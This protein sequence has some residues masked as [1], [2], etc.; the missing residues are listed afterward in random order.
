[1]LSSSP[2]AAVVGMDAT[3]SRTPGSAYYGTG[4]LPNQPDQVDDVRRQLADAMSP[5]NAG[6]GSPVK[7]NTVSAVAASPHYSDI[8]RR[9]TY[10]KDYSY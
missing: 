5:V 1:M 6:G 7:I 4:A 9:E 10:Y 8:G 2:D 3:P